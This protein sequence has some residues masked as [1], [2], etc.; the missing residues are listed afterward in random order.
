MNNSFFPSPEEVLE[1]GKS[2]VKQQAQVTTQ[3][4][5]Q[6]LTGQQAKKAQ[7]G[8]ASQSL[9]DQLNNAFI[10]DMYQPTDLSKPHMTA[11]SQNIGTAVM[12]QLGLQ[13]TNDAKSL[14]EARRKLQLLQKQH[15]EGYYIPTFE[16]RP[17]QEE[18]AGEKIER[19]EQEEKQKRWELEQ[20]K[21]KDNEV[22]I[23]VRMATNKA[24]QFRGASG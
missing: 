20:K 6:Q 14:E 21:A 17:K 24:E 12:S 9:H 15:K 19:E 7:D 8:S 13:Q 5:A 1:S 3:Q 23:A 4:V 16:Q 2:V 10:R 18:R 11:G 22:P